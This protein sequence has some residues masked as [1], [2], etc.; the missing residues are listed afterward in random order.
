MADDRELGVVEVYNRLKP[1]FASYPLKR[2]DRTPAD[3]AD[4]DDMPCVFILE[5][6][7]PIVKYSSRDFTGYPCKRVLQL[8]VEAWETADSGDSVAVKLLCKAVREV[9]LAKGGILLT[10]VVIR[11][12]KT[13]GPFNL[14][15]PGTVGM[16]IYF[17]MVYKDQGPYV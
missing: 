15:V 3:A 10:G 6:E 13:M 17:E 11:E 12:S 4:V 14:G 7:D 9:V 1:L 5:G 8:M 2:L 16:R